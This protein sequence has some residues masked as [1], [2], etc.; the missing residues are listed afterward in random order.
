MQPLAMTPKQ[1]AIQEVRQRYEQGEIPFER[2]EYAL[3]A[4]LQAQTPQECRAIIAEL[5]ISPLAA[6][7][8]LARPPAPDR[9][10]MV[11]VLGE[12]K[13]LRRPWK[14]A[15]ETIVLMAVGEVQLDLSLAA[16]P[17]RGILRVYTLIGDTKVYV[18]RSLDVTVRAFT[19]VGDVKALGEERG[20][21]CT[22]LSEEEYSAG[23]RALAPEA[24]HL[25]I[26]LI[27]L[28]GDAEVRQV[29]APVVT[30]AADTSR[31]A[32]LPRPH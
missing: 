16:L 29:D 24:P 32:R 1:A 9:R 23:E 18:P 5:P 25:E 31:S 6:L 28:V 30:I 26:Q 27:T 19:L 4:L 22:F 12:L 15:Q 11:G 8:P 7:D 2:F 20:G 3:N 21:I 10:W 13:R 14:L 17:Q